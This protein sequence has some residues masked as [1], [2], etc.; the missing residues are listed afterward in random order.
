MNNNQNASVTDINNNSSV[1]RVVKNKNY[2]TMSNVHLFNKNLSLKEKGLMS[3]CLALPDNWKYSVAGLISLSADGRDSV[4]SSIKS[5]LKEGFL[6]IEKERNEKGLFK[7]V[8]TFFENPC[9]NGVSSITENPI[10]IIRNGKSDTDNPIPIIR[11]RLS[12]TENPQLLNTN[13]QLLILNTNNLSHVN[14]EE[15]T[16]A[17][18]FNLYKK[19]CIHFPQPTKLTDERVKKTKLRLKAYPNVEFWETALKNAEKSNF[20]RKSRFVNFDWIIKNNSNPLKLFE[21]NYNNEQEQ[22]TQE[23]PKNKYSKCYKG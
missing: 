13:N 7:T 9:N 1:V 19:I 2:T 18:L 14:S 20:C 3:L 10:P 4:I 21:Q 6:K 23:Q 15:F 16:P 12:D 11:C 22:P 17:D 5:L 8:Y